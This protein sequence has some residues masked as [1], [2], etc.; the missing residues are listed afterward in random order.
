[1][2]EGEGRGVGVGANRTMAR[3]MVAPGYG[4]LIHALDAAGQN[5]SA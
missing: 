1:M 2:G 5:H 4:V 3:R